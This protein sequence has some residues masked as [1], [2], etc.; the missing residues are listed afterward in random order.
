MDSIPVEIFFHIQSYFTIKESISLQLVSKGWYA[1]I[2]S[3]LSM[4]KIKPNKFILLNDLIDRGYSPTICH[5]NLARYVLYHL[6]STRNV[7]REYLQCN[8]KY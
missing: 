5:A 3:Y 2:E 4:S 1:C 7:L 8:C 6:L